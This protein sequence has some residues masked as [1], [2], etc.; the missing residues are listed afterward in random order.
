MI[1]DP[2]D[3]DVEISAS[4]V[5]TL[6]QHPPKIKTSVGAQIRA[7]EDACGNDE[8]DVGSVADEDVAGMTCPLL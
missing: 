3:G 2:E 5:Y 6:E 4:K 7:I 1:R 8:E